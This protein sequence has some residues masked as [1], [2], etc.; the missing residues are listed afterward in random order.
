MIKVTD[1][2]KVLFVCEH[3]SGRSQMAEAYLKKYGGDRFEADS[4][5]LEAGELNPLVVE[6]MLEEDID[7]STNATNSVL[8]YFQQERRY[9]IIITVCSPE[10]S[11]KCPI[12]PGK[13]LRLNWPFA[14]PSRLSG[15]PE[16]IMADLRTIR[17]QIKY[18]IIDF[19]AEYKGKGLNIFLEENGA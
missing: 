7:I 13:T 15:E 18:K 3:N 4:A 17:N 12:F 9:D 10:V 16:E 6:A 2:I 14:D 5:G 19:V 11:E 8:S 1:M